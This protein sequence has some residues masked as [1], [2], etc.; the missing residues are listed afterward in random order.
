MTP[1]S[2]QNSQELAGA[3]FNGVGAEKPMDPQGFMIV[4]FPRESYL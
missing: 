2:T 4:I 1:A 3:S